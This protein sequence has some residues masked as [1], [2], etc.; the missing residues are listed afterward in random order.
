M[1]FVPRATHTPRRDKVRL[2]LSH[3]Y[4]MR[5]TRQGVPCLYGKSFSN[6]NLFVFLGKKETHVETRQALSN[7]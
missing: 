3:G 2:V 7:A 5:D 1:G 6:Q 4:F